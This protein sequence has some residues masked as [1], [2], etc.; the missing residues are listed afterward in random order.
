MSK[1][2]Q[3]LPVDTII[4][5]AIVLIVLVVIVAI[6]SGYFTKWMPAIDSKGQTSCNNFGGNCVDSGDCKT[7]GVIYGAKDCTTNEKPVCC[8]FGYEGVDELANI[9]EQDL[10]N[11][12]WS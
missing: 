1:K 6:F 8:K 10:K 7:L 4:I 3:C 5:A 2:A 11:D 9:D 12:D